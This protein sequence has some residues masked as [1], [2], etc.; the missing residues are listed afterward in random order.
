MRPAKSPLRALAGWL[1]ALGCAAT[2]ACAP[3]AANDD[4]ALGAESAQ[5]QAPDL[6]PELAQV[7]DVSILFP[8]AKTR[9][10]FDSYLTPKS[11][12]R[13][14]PLLGQA[15]YERA[16]GAPGTLQLG[17][18]PAAPA[19]AGLKLVAVRF[20]PCF[21]ERRVSDEASCKNQMRLVFQTLSFKSDGT[22]AADDAVH[23]FYELTREELT[24]AIKT[25]IALRTR[26]AGT[27]RLGPLGP[28]PLLQTPGGDLDVNAAREVQR[29]VTSL[30]GPA[31]LVQF[32]QF[33]PSGLDT[34]W[35][36]SGFDVQKNAPMVIPTLPANDDKHV[37]FFAG[38]TPG[39]LEGDP[40]FVP[41][42]T[43]PRAD[44]MQM[45]GNIM[46]AR[47]GGQEARKAAFEALLRIEHPGV[48]T[49]DT[50]DCASCHAVEPVRS[51]I[52]QKHF[53]GEL[54]AAKGAFEH[55]P[56]WVPETDIAPVR[57]PDSGV[58]V[59]MFSYKGKVPSVHRR[60]INESAAIVA[61]VNDRILTAR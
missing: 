57:R 59:H 56:R 32:T 60:T 22:S 55:D 29:L 58:N 40:A 48:H 8:L 46:T 39:Q 47:A 19:L 25:M 43:A 42:S 12:G 7:N 18:T 28:H 35:N 53:S 27:R 44:N 36:F 34:T 50:I 14:G 21:A 1:V 24:G 38:F 23:V 20:D 2:A 33:A 54:A 3:A 6:R 26:L 52:G 37:A 17:G 31:N 61:H 10:G 15:I 51:L 13:N 11:A 41:A 4:E 30:A 9:A 49:P 5:T 16:F 45:L